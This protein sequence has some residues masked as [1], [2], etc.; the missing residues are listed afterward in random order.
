MTPFDAIDSIRRRSTEAILG[1]TGLNHAGLAAHIRASYGDLDPR[2]GGLLQEPILEAALPNV[3][4][5]ETM[6]DLSGGLLHPSLV[7][8]LDEAEPVDRRFGREMHPFAHQLQTWRLVGDQERAN[9]VLVTSGTGSGK[10]ECFLVPIL[11]DLARQTDGQAHSLE[12]V[13]AIMLY[14]LNALIASQEERLR[15]WTAPFAG[16]LRFAL[17]NGLLPERVKAGT[18]A[19]R[20]ETVVDRKALREAPPPILVTN[21]TMLEYMLLRPQDGPI[22]AKSRGKLRYVVLD[23][24][25]TYVGAKAAEMALLLRRV[26]LAF[27][28]DPA[29]VRFI[30][31]SATIGGGA[32]VAGALR[33]FLADVSGAPLERVHVVEGRTRRPTLPPIH[34]GS[35]GDRDPFAHLGGHPKV[36]PLIERIY[37]GPTP[38]SAVEQV[39]REVG[40]SPATLAVSLAT[41]VSDANERLAP[42]RVHAFHRAAPGL[43]SCLNPNCTEPRPADWPFGAIH[44]LSADRCRCGGPLFEVVSCSDCG[45][46][47]LDV[48]ETTAGKLARPPRGP[49][50]DEFSL[51]ADR[52][53]GETDGDDS[54][55][56][57][58]TPQG[59]GDRKLIAL[60]AHGG[61]MRWLWTDA[62]SGEVR[63]REGEGL[64]RLAAFDHDVPH[65]CPACRTRAQPGAD[66]I[67][68]IRFGA[69]FILGTA[70]PILL[71]G[72]SRAPDSDDPERWTNGVVPPVM[73][74]QLLSF[75]DSRQGT[76]RLS[77]KLQVAAERN[78]VRSFVYHTV[79]DELARGGDPEKIKA[80]EEAIAE[81]EPLADGNKVLAGV[82]AD[83]R[84]E[85][86]GLLA[87]GE[88]GLP[89]ATMVDR[90][91]DRPEVR[92]WLKAV[93]ARR[94]ARFERPREL[95]E[96]L[97]LRELV[98][99]P[100]RA[101][102]P[103]TM[104]LARLRFE[105]IDAL[106]DAMVPSD[107]TGI[108]LSPRDWRDFLYLLL[109]FIARGRAA[110][111]TPRDVLHWI[112]PKVEP[113]ELVFRPDRQLAKFEVRWPHF[114]SAAIGRPPMVVSLL[115]QASGR[116]LDTLD[117]R[118]RFNDLFARA[119]GALE[120][121]LTRSG[122]TTRQLDLSAARIAPVTDAFLCPVTR[123]VLDVTLKG[124]T[125]YGAKARGA[126]GRVAEPISMPRHPLPF[127][128]EAKSAPLAEAE[129]LI[130]AWLIADATLAHLRASGAWS[131][132]GDRIAQFSDYFRSAEHSAQQPPS[133][134]RRYESEFKTGSI[135]VLN[136]STTMEMG[137]DIGSVS[138]VMMTN[139]PPSVANY[140]Q[141]VG[142]AGRRG[143]PLSMAFTFCRDQALERDAFGDPARYLGRS[144][145]PPRVALQSR[146][147][148]Q[149]HVNALLFSAFVRERGGNALTMEVGPFFGCPAAPGAPEEGDNAAAQMAA[150]AR[151]PVV[152]E[153]FAEP[154]LRLTRGSFLEGDLGVCEAAAEALDQARAAF[155]GEWR[156][157]Q[158][159]AAG[160]ADDKAAADRLRMQL[161][162]MCGDYLLG[163]L[164]DRGVLP[165]H[166]F[167]TGVVSFI[168]RQDK[169][170]QGVD[171]SEERSRFSA[172]PSRGLDVAIREYA[173]GSEVVL[174]GLVHRSAGVTLNWRRPANLD[175][176]REVQAIRLRWRCR[177]CGESGVAPTA[178]EAAECP[179][180]HQAAADWAEYLQPA[181]FA[182][183]LR[184][185]PHADADVVT[186]V[187]AEP[188]VVSA[189][190]AVWT[191]LFDPAR[192][193]RRGTSE[194]SVFFCNAGPSGDGY[195][196]CL[197]CG[198]ADGYDPGRPH[199]PL[200]GKG[201]DCEG[202]D[203]PFAR[204][205]GLLLGHEIRTDVFELQPAGWPDRGGALALAVALR[206][207]LARRLGI[208]TDEMG[209]SAEPRLDAFGA[210]TMS[211]FL[212][213]KASGGAGFAVKAGE[214][215]ADLLE[216]MEQIL[217]CKVEGCDRACPA[218]VLASDLVED[219]VR[220]LDRRSALALVR[221]RLLADAAPLEADRAGP[222]ARFCLDL[223]D[224]L[225]QAMERGGTQL[226]L[227]LAG[228]LDPAALSDWSAAKL[229]RHWVGR[230][231]SAVL[232]V[233]RGAIE[234]LSG[235]ELLLL[236]DLVNRW[237]VSLEEGAVPTCAN[238]GALVAEVVSADGSALIF[239]TRDEA[240]AQVS[241]AWGRP[242]T[243]PIVRFEAP[244]ALWHGAPV[245]ASRLAPPPGATL[246]QLGHELDG[247]IA[248]FG[249]R[250]AAMLREQLQIAGVPRDEVVASLV[251]EDRYLLSPATLR[252]C[253][254][255]L[256]AV[257][258]APRGSES[259]PL[260]VRTFEVR[261]APTPSPWLDNDW[262]L[263][264][265]RSA[266]AG[267][268]AADRGLALDLRLTRPEHGRR[269]TLTFASGR[270][271]LVLF[272][273][274]FGAWRPDRGARFDFT[275]SLADQVRQLQTATAMVRLPQGART[276]VISQKA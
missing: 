2:R 250:A 235:A 169:P 166:G 230:G 14:P 128:G 276:Y 49:V 210:Q 87:A 98:R 61:A 171:L 33:Q 56:G 7:S 159:V 231:R 126:P 96:F 130:G 144:L 75:T 143:Q 109:T 131:D 201:A 127:R 243:A 97:L 189:R 273:Q 149:R 8:A 186:Y 27:G 4:A 40:Y 1:Q 71:E 200:I 93:W 224:D 19:A 104:G 262:P 84:R 47:F 116:S 80:A 114:A 215:F 145:A 36:R 137:V 20:P 237:S 211:I 91:A 219:D 107:W 121:L 183:D 58:G 103:E 259:T 51:D 213:D 184:V 271:A 62:V 198:R 165:G 90:L 168:S 54:D 59:P 15:A 42:M 69:P 272:D 218:C 175:G 221:E 254:D 225:Q 65:V 161:H 142:R 23:E 140:R 77:A 223:L 228:P 195:A 113:K 253:L 120:P 112:T 86:A 236:R 24:A 108:G 148:V 187:P 132:L 205:E 199:P 239:A 188:A 245:E 11:D 5:D 138:H 150:W 17:Y 202:S 110:V 181:G 246:R 57:G 46:P 247:P 89:W 9:S 264:A 214:L 72:A 164:A 119:W 182:A 43:W 153:R 34:D 101:N 6:D 274:G 167:P 147:I 73:G 66:L 180:C 163:V 255:T 238:G 260:T 10:T 158:A 155:A 206:E 32:A 212:H 190:G 64:T 48:I 44:H 244:H 170:E 118:E 208:G 134:L 261:P 222:D 193:R 105:T 139:L 124:L 270:R 242:E 18:Y 229:A 102:A 29:D 173:P 74:R 79:Q 174:D 117:T 38:W 191:G 76:A 129:S 94:D 265:H 82:L 185:E 151:D 52:D 240:A 67:R 157:V 146:V 53:P 83:K 234:A 263:E 13:Q 241:D 3:T 92:V 50:A 133:K 70:T 232:A 12:G 60:G 41:A 178:P 81:L 55:E 63:D 26:C 197:Y 88:R 21:V 172:F 154:L 106:P 100:P 135:N 192:G 209:L 269:L 177:R 39:A 258:A 252:L 207:A 115:E 217:D 196:V 37:D 125:P 220:R 22:L 156:S 160:R 99:R 268:Y 122:A 28:V 275:R 266:V 141:R 78:F 136:C 204:K 25:H 203:K 35:K 123:R 194:G 257:V 233:D 16:K 95:A 216:G 111:R 256:A 152:A 267:A 45:E 85:L 226:T 176:V 248:G 68:P 249:A 162:R 227:R 30:A 251:Y 179:A 31:T